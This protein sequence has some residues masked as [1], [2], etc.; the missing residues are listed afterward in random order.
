MIVIILYFYFDRSCL[1]VGLS[2]CPKFTEVQGSCCSSPHDEMLVWGIYPLWIRILWPFFEFSF[3]IS[4]P[5][6]FSLVQFNTINLKG[7]IEECLSYKTAWI[8]NLLWSFFVIFLQVFI[9]VFLLLFIHSVPYL[10]IVHNRIALLFGLS[11]IIVFVVLHLIN[12]LWHQVS[13]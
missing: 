5:R 13:P 11:F 10:V 12:T 8:G 6:Y 3:T 9:N 4:F 2:P 1:D 7:V